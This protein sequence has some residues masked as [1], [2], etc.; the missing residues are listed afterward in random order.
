MRNWE[1]FYFV[2]GLIVSEGVI[3][4]CPICRLTFVDLKSL[5]THVYSHAVDDIFYCPM[6]PGV[7]RHNSYQQRYS[8]SGFKFFF[9]FTQ[10]FKTY[11]LIRKHIRARHNGVKFRC[12]YC[13]RLL[14]SRFSLALHMLR[15][16]IIPLDDF[17]D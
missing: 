11:K 9:F 12:E 13:S 8:I 6:C 14:N 2:R 3:Y 1:I 7:V 16:D 15:C 10:Q 4:D 17:R 5:K